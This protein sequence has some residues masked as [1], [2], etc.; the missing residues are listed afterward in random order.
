[1]P[2][3]FT[4]FWIHFV[5]RLFSVVPSEAGVALLSMT[6]TVIFPVAAPVLP[7]VFCGLLTVPVVALVPLLS[8]FMPEA[9]A[10]DVSGADVSASPDDASSDGTLP[11]SAGAAL[12]AAEDGSAPLSPPSGA[13]VH[14]QR[15][16]ASAAENAA[17]STRRYKTLAVISSLPFCIR[18]ADLSLAP[19]RTAQGTA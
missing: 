15:L 19:F 14:E 8:G 11:L 4:C 13:G 6:I 10:S 5:Q 17:A 12:S 3:G 16:R 7:S 18:A 2:M 1:M 9:D